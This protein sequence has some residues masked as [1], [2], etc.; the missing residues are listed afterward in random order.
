MYKGPLRMFA[1][2]HDSDE[3]PSVDSCLMSV[4]KHTNP[5][6]EV[7]KKKKR[8]RHENNIGQIQDFLSI[9]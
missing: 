7:K 1:F 6:F 4:H 2:Y 3:N 9:C 8:E 5:V